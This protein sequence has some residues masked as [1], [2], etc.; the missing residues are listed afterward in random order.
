MRTP[1]LLHKS[2]PWGQELYVGLTCALLGNGA[3]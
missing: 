2:F 3:L 1:L